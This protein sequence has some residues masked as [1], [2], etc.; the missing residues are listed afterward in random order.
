MNVLILGSGG[1]EHAF[2]WKIAKSSHINDLYIAPGNAGTAKEGI[3]VEIEVDDFEAIATFCLE[4]RID[5]ILVGP[6]LP[7]VKGIRDYFEQ[8]IALKN[9]GIIGPNKE[10]AKL[11]GSKKFAK[12]FMDKHN[13]P[14]SKYK[15]FNASNIESAYAFLKDIISLIKVENTYNK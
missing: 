14:T 1:R 4:K 12:E 9:I 15:S 10:G 2:A 6:E 5:M 13:I 8:N 11:E 3:N 7:L